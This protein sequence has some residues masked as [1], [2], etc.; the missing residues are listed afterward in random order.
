ME[1]PV[2]DD[3]PHHLPLKVWKCQGEVAIEFLT[4][5]FN[6]IFANETMP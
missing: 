3:I 4:K 5:I 2:P 6:K 1:R